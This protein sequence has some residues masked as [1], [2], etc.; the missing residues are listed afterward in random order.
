VSA[1]AALLPARSALPNASACSR[2]H[3]L[4]ASAVRTTRGLLL[5]LLLLLLPLLLVARLLSA[6]CTASTTA[7][8][9][10]G[11]GLQQE[12]AQWRQGHT[13]AHGK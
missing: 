4:L 1:S 7:A 5:L 3:A 2:L 10:A 9:S 6:A 11:S 12:G 13:H 8:S